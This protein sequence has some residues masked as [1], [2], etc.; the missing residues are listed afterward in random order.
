[1][2]ISIILQAYLMGLWIITR[3]MLRTDQMTTHRPSFRGQFVLVRLDK[4]EKYTIQAKK[5]LLFMCS[6]CIAY[7]C[8]P[9]SLFV[10]SFKSYLVMRMKFKLW[11]KRLS[12]ISLI[13]R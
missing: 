12:V 3:F 1:M 11:V 7:L 13:I 2:D 10:R 4:S 6:N 5:A 9:V 8:Y